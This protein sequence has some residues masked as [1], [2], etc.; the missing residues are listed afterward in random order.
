MRAAGLS[1]HPRGEEVRNE[2]VKM[3]A[4]Q[5]T[6][7]ETLLSETCGT[8]RDL[9][10]R[11]QA[12]YGTP[13]P[14]ADQRGGSGAVNRGEERGGP[15]GSWIQ[16]GKGRW[17][18]EEVTIHLLFFSSQMRFTP[19]PFWFQSPKRCPTVL[20]P[21][22]PASTDAPTSPV[23]PNTGQRPHRRGG[24]LSL[25]RL[26]Q[27]P[28]QVRPRSDNPCKCGASVLRALRKWWA[29]GWRV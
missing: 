20:R 8:P 3:G 28:L 10:C 18:S 15:K 6:A 12:A 24:R 14:V 29:E 4:A 16:L 1:H 11:P 2:G 27:R 26:A 25:A 17:D 7:L 22:V 19:S 5:G 23:R 13:A 9:R 21:T